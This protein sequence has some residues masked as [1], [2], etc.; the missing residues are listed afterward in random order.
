M[1]KKP[2]EAEKGKGSRRRRGNS[3]RP[4]LQEKAVKS[5]KTDNCLNH[6]QRTMKQMILKDEEAYR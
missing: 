3:G 6:L 5:F 2:K 1:K 4:H